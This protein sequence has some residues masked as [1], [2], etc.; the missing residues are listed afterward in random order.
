MKLAGIARRFKSSSTS[1]SR[2]LSSTAATQHAVLRKEHCFAQSEVSKFAVLSGDTNPI[3]TDPSAAVSAGFSA[4]IVHGMLCVSLCS[5]LISSRFP[6]AIYESKS[7][8]FKEPALVGD[9]L[10]AEVKVLSTHPATDGLRMQQVQTL[11]RA[12]KQYSVKVD[13]RHGKATNNISGLPSIQAGNREHVK[14]P[15]Q[16][17]RLGPRTFMKFHPQWRHIVM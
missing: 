15:K 1:P 2:P 17:P 12:K 4:C 11:L 5:S 10:E 16:T 7:F 6:G 14:S 8:R 3:H 13:A 9:C